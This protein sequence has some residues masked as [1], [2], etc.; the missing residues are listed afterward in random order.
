[1]TEGLYPVELRFSTDYPALPPVARFPA[2][3]FHP[4]IY[5]DGK[6]SPSRSMSALLQRAACRLSSVFLLSALWR[7]AAYLLVLHCMVR[8]EERKTCMLAQVC[9]SIL[10]P[11]KA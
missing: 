4:N 9:L 1:M 8:M 2:G 3:F 7:H 11:E 10:N 5:D 6:A